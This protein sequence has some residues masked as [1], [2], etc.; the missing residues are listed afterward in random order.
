MFLTTGSSARVHTRIDSLDCFYKFL[1]SISFAV[2]TGMCAQIR[3]QLPFTPV[4]VTAQTVAVLLSG[5]VLGP[6]FG[7]LSQVMYLMWGV[8]G[9]PWFSGMLGGYLTV[10]QPT[11]GYILG[12]I[13]GAFLAGVI[14]RQPAVV[15]SFF[16]RCA[17]FYGTTFIIYTF[18]CA[19][20]MALL[21]G[22]WRLAVSLG[23]Y[24]FLLVDFFKAAFLAAAMPLFL[25]GE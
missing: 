5:I 2:L 4:P 9:M 16:I 1:L 3:L 25:A 24:P 17:G 14:A 23:V 20:L 15:R 10:L 11:F 12:F 19:H 22:N 21:G 8:V 13:P 6:F 18:G 7:A